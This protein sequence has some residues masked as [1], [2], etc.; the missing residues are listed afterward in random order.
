MT[1]WSL[2]RFVMIPM[3]PQLHSMFPIN[4]WTSTTGSPS[5]GRCNGSARRSS[6]RT[7]PALRLL[8]EARQ[9]STIRIRLSFELLLSLLAE[10]SPGAYHEMNHRRLSRVKVRNQPGPSGFPIPFHGDLRNA[11]CYGGLIF[12]QAGE[13]TQ[14]HHPGGSRIDDGESG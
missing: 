6:Q 2:E 4:P 8:P 13:E 7:C 12:L 5:H 3:S 14:F 11:Q 1:W 10:G 9:E